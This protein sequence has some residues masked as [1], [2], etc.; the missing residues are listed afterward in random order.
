[1]KVQF[2]LRSQNQNDKGAIYLEVFDPRLK[3]RRY[4]Y[5]TGL[6]V[7][8]QYCAWTN[9][10]T[11]SK[12]K[13][14][15]FEK[16]KI[17]KNLTPL[18]ARKLTAIN[19]H[20]KKLRA[21]V[22]A[23]E[24]LKFDSSTL[25][26]AELKAHMDSFKNDDRKKAKDLE[27]EEKQKAEDQLQRELD[28]FQTWQTIIDT[29]KNPKTGQ[30]ITA[31][32]KRSKAQTKHK[33]EEFCNA[34][35][36]SPT[37]ES[38]DMAFYHAFI[39]YMEA[40]KLEP[41]TMGKHIKELKAILRECADR[42]LKVNTAYLKKSF[43][44]IRQQVDSIYLNE[45]QLRV[46]LEGK[47]EDQLTPAEIRQRDIFVC[48]C[49]VGARH[50]DWHQ[51]KNVNIEMIDGKAVLRI[52][53]KKTNEAIH[54]PLHPIVE[55][56]LKKYGGQLPKIVPNQTFNADLKEIGKKAKLKNWKDLTTHTAR[57]SFCTNAYLSG[58]DVHQIM[59]CSGH[60][61]ESSFLRYLKLEGID[62]AIKASEQKFFQPKAHMKIAV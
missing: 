34:N 45:E 6:Y 11:G 54:V 46:L 9:S 23:F 32:T 57:R 26:T 30:K 50:S 13:Q 15:A 49:Y 60:K 52:N 2:T 16:L 39:K 25:D 36:I 4:R 40:E 21:Q 18:E 58:M 29:T 10:K 1:M 48:G 3:G 8:P 33:V 62:F 20:L 53:Q 22:E 35:G 42:D 56:I 43:K 38:I 19:E 59:Q 5:A 37:L 61:S 55:T 31:G 28:F 47:F 24:T 51:I 12:I 41:N 14:G 27:L 17:S 44:V 7:E